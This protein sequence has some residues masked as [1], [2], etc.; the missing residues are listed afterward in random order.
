MEAQ[1]KNTEMFLI[2]GTPLADFTIVYQSGSILAKRTAILLMA[3]L[4]EKFGICLPV[5]EDDSSAEHKI[6]I[7]GESFT[8]IAC[9]RHEFVMYATPN[10]LKATF[11]S[12]FAYER[13]RVYLTEELFGEC[14]SIKKSWLYAEDITPTLDGGRQY[15]WERQGDLRVLT[16]NI[17][18]AGKSGEERMAY[19][20]CTFDEYAPDILLLQEVSVKE[21]AL[22]NNISHILMRSG[23]R[24]IFEDCDNNYEPVLIRADRFDVIEHGNHIFTMANNFDSKQVSFAVLFDRQLKRTLAVFSTHF[25][26]TDDEYGLQSKLQNVKELQEIC[27][28]IHKKYNCPIIGGGDLNG[29]KYQ[30]HIQKLYEAGFENTHCKAEYKNKWGTCS[31]RCVPDVELG[32]LVGLKDII[33]R[34]PDYERYIIDHIVTYGTHMSVKTN[35]VI[36]DE[37][38]RLGTDHAILYV[39]VDYP[40]V[41]NE[42]A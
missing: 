22:E 11:T 13:L 16:A 23:Y 41:E 29:T 33:N 8:G 31:D 12:T 40:K 1:Q 2:S 35:I 19:L 7:G 4:R 15:A 42:E 18:G 9:A 27:S 3:H 17:F 30:D 38:V 24:E 14:R 32:I 36:A 5:C 28:Y 10:H 39:D 6:V 21:T 25:W 26:Y 37:C 34:T 20:K